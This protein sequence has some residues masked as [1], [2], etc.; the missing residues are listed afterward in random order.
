MRRSL[1]TYVAEGADETECRPLARRAATASAICAVSV[2]EV[3][4]GMIDLEEATKTSDLEPKSYDAGND[5]SGEQCPE[6]V[7]TETQHIGDEGDVWNLETPETSLDEVAVPESVHKPLK[8]LIYQTN[9]RFYDVDSN[10][11]RYK[12]GLSRKGLAVPSLHHKKSP[13]SP[14]A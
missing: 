12:A 14:A 7:M 9:K 11:V 3:G 2:V 5:E 8:D 10:K 1:T 4:L 6:E 13:D